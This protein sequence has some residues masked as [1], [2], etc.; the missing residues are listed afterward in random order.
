[1]RQK[2]KNINKAN[3]LTD[4]MKREALPHSLPELPV[5]PCNSKDLK[6]IAI[7]HLGK[8]KTLL[9]GQKKKK[10]GREKLSSHLG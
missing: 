5:Y 1:M 9:H 6:K 10:K 7:E 2:K 3:M 8:E 4:R